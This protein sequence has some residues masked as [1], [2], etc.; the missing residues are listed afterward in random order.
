[1]KKRY[2]Q[3]LDSQKLVSCGIKLQNLMDRTAFLYLLDIAVRRRFSPFDSE[4]LQH[5]PVIENVA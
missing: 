2:F 3:K 1:M 5:I 4:K